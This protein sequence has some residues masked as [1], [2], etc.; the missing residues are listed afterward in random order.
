[1][2]WRGERQPFPPVFASVLPALV[3][4][5]PV[6]TLEARARALGVVIETRSTVDALPSGPIILATELAS[7]ARLLGKPELCWT[8]AHSALFDVALRDD[9]RDPVAV[10]DL[11]VRV[12]VARYTGYDPSLAPA[13]EQLIQCCAG[14]RDD[15][16][17][18]KMIWVLNRLLREEAA[19]SGRVADIDVAA[20]N[21][22]TLGSTTP[23]PGH[24]R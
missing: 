13:G 20:T 11:D 23:S 24:S 6:A 3:H 4:T 9:E 15:E 12:Y 17:P 2:V 19:T 7:A 18:A 21:V 22:T 14:I 16:G 10:L 1:M 8:G 5:A